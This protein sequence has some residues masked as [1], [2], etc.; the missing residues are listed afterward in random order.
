MWRLASLLLLPRARMRSKGLS[1]HLWCPSIYMWPK[2]FF[3][4]RLNSCNSIWQWELTTLYSCHCPL[5]LRSCQ[6][7]SKQQATLIIGHFYST[8]APPPMHTTTH[9]RSSHHMASLWLWSRPLHCS[10]APG[11][12]TTVR[13][14]CMLHEVAQ[15]TAELHVGCGCQGA[16]FIVNSKYKFSWSCSGV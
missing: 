1:N 13:W 12:Y 4:S 14:D 5:N 11:R 3:K 16:S 9:I 8:T 7:S 2:N 6:Q 15:L 10:G